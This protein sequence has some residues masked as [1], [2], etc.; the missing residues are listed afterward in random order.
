[1]AASAAGILA[2]M[3]WMVAGPLQPGWAKA[4][5]TPADLLAGTA[6]QSAPARQ[7]LAAG[8]DDPVSGTLVQSQTTAT[9]TM[10]DT[11]NTSLKVVIVANAD[12]SGSLTVSR[13]GSIL[14][15]G[16]AV[17]GATTVT[18]GCGSVRV[19]VDLVNRDGIISGTLSTQRAVP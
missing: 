6:I 14:C 19:T 16:P 13:S 2:L 3:A 5:G 7:S 1:M 10:T 9:A 12:G 17:I 15:T 8:L 18:A 4:A 11:R